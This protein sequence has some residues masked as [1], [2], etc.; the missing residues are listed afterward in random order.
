[1]PTQANRCYLAVLAFFFCCS[2]E[3]RAEEPRDVFREGF[4]R[5]GSIIVPAQIMGRN[6]TCMLD[7]GASTC[8][9]DKRFAATLQKPA[10]TEQVITASGLVTVEQ[11]AGISQQFMTLPHVTGPAIASDLSGMTNLVGIELDA[12]FGMDL[13]KRS[14]LQFSNGVPRFRNRNDVVL[15]G[16]SYPV[17]TIRRCPY[18][19]VGLPVLGDRPF[20]ID[21]GWA[22]Y[23]GITKDYADRLIRSNDAMFVDA[24]VRLDAS[25]IRQKN[26]YVIREITVFGIRIYDVP[27]LE[28]DVDLIGLGVLR[29]LELSVDFEND[30][31][32]VHKA[33]D[34]E[35]S[36]DLDASGLR[37]VIQPD[38]RVVVHVTM[39][40]S[41]AEKHK[42]QAGN[43]LL[44]IDGRAAANLAYWDIRR[45]LSQAGSTIPIKVKSG[46][47]VR[48]IE[49]PLRRNFEYPPKWKPR[50]TEA[51]DFLKSLENKA[52]P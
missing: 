2:V 40:D 46:D 42:I 18:I 26:A 30:L 23:C 9:L 17:T 5:S 8:V 39:P 25:G 48:D 13:L 34:G 12:V 52:K 44:E 11:Y 47:Q 49:L 22:S 45:L 43:Q 3:L 6:V 28:S 24:T 31:A 32:Y 21:T 4:E 20:L 10:G 15:D 41:P 14:I 38:R 7:T 33:F 51:E 1:V 35:V 19:S 16:L 50:S 37:T 36:F 29:Q 27:A